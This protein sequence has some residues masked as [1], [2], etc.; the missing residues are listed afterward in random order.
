MNG[1][2]ILSALQDDFCFQVFGAGE[3]EPDCTTTT[4]DEALEHITA[5]DETIVYLWAGGRAMGCLFIVMDGDGPEVY[6]YSGGE[7]IMKRL[8]SLTQED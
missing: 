7:E 6:D 4:A 8:D 1:R 2:K 5:H 3:L